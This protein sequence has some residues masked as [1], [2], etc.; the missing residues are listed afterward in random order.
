MSTITL[1]TSTLAT[2]CHLWL[3]GQDSSG[4][5]TLRYLGVPERAHRAM[6]RQVNGE[7]PEGMLIRHKCDNRLCTNVDH[8]ELGTIQQN[9]DDRERRGRGSKGEHRP[10]SILKV[11]NVHEI[12]ESSLTRKELATKFGVSTKTISNVINGK[13]WRSV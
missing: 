13:K 6:W 10:S 4:Y 7:I 5:G 11:E 8:L 12:R 1:K 9:M 2:D 3:W